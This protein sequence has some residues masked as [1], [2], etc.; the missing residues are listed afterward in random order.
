M[1][2]LPSMPGGS[3]VSVMWGQSCR[4][5]TYCHIIMGAGTF[6][7]YSL[8]EVATGALILNPSAKIMG[9][10]ACFRAV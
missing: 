4:V 5:H 9:M 6:E 3:C 7:P 1:K 2:K 10:T 8:G